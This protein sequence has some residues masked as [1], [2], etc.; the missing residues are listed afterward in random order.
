MIIVFQ[1][2]DSLRI[3]ATS[4]SLKATNSRET[5][6]GFYSGPVFFRLFAE[7][8]ESETVS[9]SSAPSKGTF[10]RQLPF[11]FVFR[12]GNSRRKSSPKLWP[13]TI[14]GVGKSMKPFGTS[15]DLRK[16]APRALLVFSPRRSLDSQSK[17]SL[18]PVAYFETAPEM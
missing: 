3:E 1:C 5:R 18:Y 9:F 11:S 14:I 10:S 17:G 2:A 13:R 16:L 6:T 8:T 15:A 7:L 4:F 12:T